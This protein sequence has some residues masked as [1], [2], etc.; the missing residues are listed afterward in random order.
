MTSAFSS[1]VDPGIAA[2]G[3]AALASAPPVEAPADSS[4]VVVPFSE[5]VDQALSAGDRR[6]TSAPDLETSDEDLSH[7]LLP[8]SRRP[9]PPPAI[10]ESNVGPQAPGPAEARAGDSQ[11]NGQ[12]P[13]PPTCDVIVET[14]P[15]ATDGAAPE[16]TDATPTESASQ[17]PE[18]ES[19][20]TPNARPSQGSSA[21]GRTPGTPASRGHGQ[22]SSPPPA[23]TVVSI[24]PEVSPAS[25]QSPTS[26][27]DAASARET[28]ES[29]VSGPAAD[30][31][32]VEVPSDGRTPTVESPL[33]AAPTA[34]DASL[35]GS[36]SVAAPVP[37]SAATA[38]S[39]TDQSAPSR[40]ESSSRPRVDSGTIAR[41]EG[42]VANAGTSGHVGS[43]D[44]DRRVGTEPGAVEGGPA[45]SP[46]VRGL[47]VGAVGHRPPATPTTIDRGPANLSAP[48]TVTGGRPVQVGISDP[49]ALT[50]TSPTSSTDDSTGI[51]PLIIAS[52]ETTT[53]QHEPGTVASTESDAILP[54]VDGPIREEVSKTTPEVPRGPTSVV[55][56]GE[57]DGSVTIP[58]ARAAAVPGSA[59][60]VDEKQQPSIRSPRGSVEPP[61]GPDRP[62]VAT[63]QPTAKDEISRPL[64]AA[65]FDRGARRDAISSGGFGRVVEPLRIEHAG[66]LRFQSMPS[67]TAKAPA[68]ADGLSASLPDDAI[69]P[70]TRAGAIVSSPQVSVV[71]GVGERETATSDATVVSTSTASAEAVVEGV[72]PKESSATAVRVNGPAVQ[73][74]EAASNR[75]P[76]RELSTEGLAPLRSP[77]SRT[78]DSR[79]VDSRT[80]D[81]RT[82]ESRTV[83][84]R[85]VESRTVDSMAVGSGRRVGTVL[86]DVQ[87]P[88][89][90]P[91]PA[92]DVEVP[93]TEAT[94]VGN[95]PAGSGG[96]TPLMDPRAPAV[97]AG[98]SET[99]RTPVGTGADDEVAPAVTEP[100][101]VG[102]E[103]P[104]VDANSIT[105]LEPV[106]SEG[107]ELGG[108]AAAATTAGTV[109][110]AEV[111]KDGKTATLQSISD[112]AKRASGTP[113]AEVGSGMKKGRK[114]SKAAEET[115]HILPVDREGLSGLSLP[116]FSSK[117]TSTRRPVELSRAPEAE[118]ARLAASFH[119]DSRWEP[120]QEI[121]AVGSTRVRD[122]SSRVAQI[123]SFVAREAGVVRKSGA[124]SLSVVFRPDSKTELV[125]QLNQSS[126]GV[127]ATI[128]CERGQFPAAR[129]EWDQLR[130]ALAAQN[131]RLT[132]P[133]EGVLAAVAADTSTGN[134][135]RSAWAEDRFSRG[136]Q[137]S[138]PQQQSP[139]HHQQQQTSSQARQESG[140]ETRPRPGGVAGTAAKTAST[141]PR[142]V[143]RGGW[144]SWA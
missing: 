15:Q 124:Q 142:P 6:P 12:A 11:E 34:V 98:S 8:N 90:T 5:L 75:P 105:N 122:H 140:Y 58:T 60:V 128:R 57:L 114:P 22:P 103:D 102:M 14:D 87:E 109:Q 50:S 139:Q 47:E 123:E 141:S 83:E 49:N 67:G 39:S 135:S 120:G 119:A 116:T 19:P 33:S 132:P 101:A 134:G 42:S 86:D 117:E 133:P 80:V 4:R 59:T 28:T 23:P 35:A 127:E 45:L 30:D 53:S 115:L 43:P 104:E 79:T 74:L 99:S 95:R 13:E 55:D 126:T 18:S 24:S 89:T 68:S 144:E 129:G 84:S 37:V 3:K 54:A 7:S 1:L 17:S 76:R 94:P 9:F 110:R 21:R 40:G 85:T 118:E 112:E 121:D 106:A 56:R 29:S 81:S 92:P 61:A 27:V 41:P 71:P 143:R 32:T 52:M 93:I 137:Q 125:V 31:D 96:E 38:S 62:R 100:I 20:E 113:I 48:T 66:F 138:G 63:D 97:P 107:G 130:D 25:T 44:R 65:D 136:Q 72:A 73:D 88:A 51:D 26:I 69:V 77:D 2:A 46:A 36:G 70:G 16:S 111:R 82:V 10:A 108:L 131:I 78:V 91:A 64:S